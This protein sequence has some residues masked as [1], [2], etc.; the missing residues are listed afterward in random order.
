MPECFIV[1]LKNPYKVFYQASYNPKFLKYYLKRNYL[2]F[3]LM[4]DLIL[5]QICKRV[6]IIWGYLDT[7]NNSK[8]LYDPVNEKF[9][10]EN[11]IIDTKLINRFIKKINS[12]SFFTHKK[13]LKIS[14]IGESNHLGSSF[15]M[16]NDPIKFIVNSYGKINKF[17]N[18]YIIDSS[19][20]PDIAPGPLTLTVMA[21]SMRVGDHALHEE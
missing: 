1:D 17:Q 13:L 21:N 5:N 15:S 14:K 12:F 18:C 10:Y 11:K 16:G 8:I 6:L 7:K 20:L 19:I 3:K 4:P 9:T 2:L